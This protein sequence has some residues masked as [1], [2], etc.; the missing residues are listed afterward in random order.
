MNLS[1]IL[2]IP[3]VTA[4]LVALARSASQVRG[5]SLIGTVVQLAGAIYLLLSFSGIRKAGNTGIVL[6]E[7]QYPIFPSI[8]INYHVGV[9][10]ISVA[11]IL[12]T[13]LVV[14]A[15]VLISWKEERMTKEY[16]LLLLMLSLGAY[17][18]LFRSIFSF[19]SPSSKLRLFQNTC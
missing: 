7:Q 15:G 10:G 2:L 1:L 5:I 14:L 16:Y 6:F 4:L 9:D 17:G 3:L 19:Y 18:F 8:G 13:S 11:M 12:L